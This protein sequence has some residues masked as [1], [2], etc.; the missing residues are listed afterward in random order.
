M[1]QNIQAGI[2]LSFLTQKIQCGHETIW[3]Y[4]N[5]CLWT[6]AI[7]HMQQPKS[8]S[9]LSKKKIVYVKHSNCCSFLCSNRFIVFLLITT[10][11]SDVKEYYIE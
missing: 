3:N 8:I 11:N 4:G 7:K 2:N 10:A 6:L 5:L 1:I 9:H